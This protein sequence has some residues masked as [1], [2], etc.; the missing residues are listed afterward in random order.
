MGWSMEEFLA[1]WAQMPEDAT[2]MEP[3]RT[4]QSA[5]T[6]SICLRLDDFVDRE[7][8][9]CRFDSMEFRELIHYTELFPQESVK[10]PKD[11]RTEYQ[12]VIEHDQML[13]QGYLCNFRDVTMD[14]DYLQD[15][16]V[17][18]GLPGA[19]GNGSSFELSGGF[20]MAENS[21]HKE[22]AWRFL[23]LLL[24]A[25]M[26]LRGDDSFFVG[27]PSNRIAFETLMDREMKVEYVTDADGNY[28]HD[29]NGEKI[30]K[31]RGMRQLGENG[32]V[33]PVYPMTREQADAL[34][35]LINTTTC[36]R[37]WDG[38]VMDIVIEEIGAYYA[39]DRSLDKACEN[40]QRRVQL[41]LEEQK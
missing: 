5:L 25:E 22:G 27:F 6:T 11:S 9:T 3:W 16:V 1:A 33:I 36:V 14:T 13:I 41:Y 40:I 31:S 26:Q 20:A 18:V 37:Y 4:R 12:R 7:N 17:Y 21:R 29:A 19:S 23:H 32:P 30:P 10:D 8:A 34:M 15:Q 2:I 28:L 38:A 35:N 24:D 39:G